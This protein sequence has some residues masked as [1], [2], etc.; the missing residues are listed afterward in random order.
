MVETMGFVPCPLQ[1]RRGSRGWADDVGVVG[2]LGDRGVGV[3]RTT[4]ASLVLWQGGDSRW[5]TEN[6]GAAASRGR[7]GHQGLWGRP[8]PG[9]GASEAVYRWCRC[10]APQPPAH[11]SGSLRD[12]DTDPPQITSG[13]LF[14][15]KFEQK[16]G[17]GTLTLRCKA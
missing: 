17:L 1:G 15:A 6:K 12:G 11:G 14:L 4:W 5:V 8:L 9:S 16:G 7:Q 13:K 2:P 10:V 3:G